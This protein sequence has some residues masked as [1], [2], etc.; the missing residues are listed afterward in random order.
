[1]TTTNRGVAAPYVAGY[2]AL[3]AAATGYLALRYADWVFPVFS[4]GV[5]GVALSGIAWLTTRGAKPRPVTV[6]RPALE[7]GAVIAYLALYALVFL[8]WGMGALRQDIPP[9]QAQELAVLAAKLAVHVAA[10]VL[11][12]ALL[13]ARIAPLFGGAA[14]RR[15]VLLTLAVLAP[16]LI[17]LLSVVSPSL[18]QIGALHPSPAELLW[19]APFTFVWIALEAGLCEEVLFRAVLQTRLAAVLKSETG[20]VLIGA[21]IFA[22]CHVPGL[23]LRGGPGVDGWSADPLQ[24]AAFTVA[25]LSPIA[26]MF[27]LIWA[28]TRSLIL[29]VLLHACVDVLPNLPDTL[30]TWAGL[31]GT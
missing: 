14:S 27:G 19:A 16:I 10:P 31:G 20:A 1:M 5:F 18:K 2:M 22:L 29:V 23:Y 24:V 13:G 17:G 3:W 12:L 9:G 26:V 11:I 30:K 28:R 21:V 4:L 6:E 25:T 15:G 8:G 7:L